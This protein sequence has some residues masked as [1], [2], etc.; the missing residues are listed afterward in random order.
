MKSVMPKAMYVKN[1]NSRQ[2][3]TTAFPQVYMDVYVN[4]FKN[5]TPN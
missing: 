5:G 3:D 2:D 4:V 1:K